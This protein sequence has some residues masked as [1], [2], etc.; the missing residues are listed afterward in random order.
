[1]YKRALRSFVGAL[2]VV[3]LAT[4]ALRARTALRS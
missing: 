2:V 4:A 3:M 1:M